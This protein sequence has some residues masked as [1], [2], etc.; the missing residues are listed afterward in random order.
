MKN[1]IFSICTVL[2]S[3]IA[4]NLLAAPFFVDL[5][6]AAT[7]NIEDDGIADNHKGGWTDEG[8]N[9]MYNYPAVPLGDISRNGYHFHII[10]SAKNN[11]KSVII[12]KGLLRARNNPE[13]V[14][15]KVPDVKGKY[16]YFLQN[17]VA[18]VKEKN[19]NYLVAEYTV[20]YE[21][22][23]TFKIPIRNEQEIHQ[24][25]KKREKSRESEA[26]S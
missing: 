19:K 2:T 10:D 4:I 22:G 17:A 9:D 5:K 23:S 12:L 16:I 24:W 15:L 11:G 8:I 18:N 1:C 7:S 25:W 20:T 14:T 3:F 26:C 6:S 13:E 21:D